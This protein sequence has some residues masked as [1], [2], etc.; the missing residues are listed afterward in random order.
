MF[1]KGSIESGPRPEV[2]PT[3]LTEEDLIPLHKLAKELDCDLGALHR[4][5]LAGTLSRPGPNGERRRVYLEVAKVLGRHY[6]SRQAWC[7]YLRACNSTPNP[8]GTNGSGPGD[9]L[10]A[11]STPTRRT[12]AQRRAAIERANKTA[13]ALGA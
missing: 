12:A 3:V 9:S 1:S 13:E 2:D 7:R 6:T 11:P 4:A 8:S 5:A 10:A